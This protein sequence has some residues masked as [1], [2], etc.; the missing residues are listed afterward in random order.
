MKPRHV[1]ISYWNQSDTETGQVVIA[2]LEG[3]DFFPPLALTSWPF[4][5]AGYPTWQVTV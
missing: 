1:C 2:M 5:N 3:R 4:F